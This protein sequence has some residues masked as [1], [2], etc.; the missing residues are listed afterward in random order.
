[1]ITGWF[2]HKSISQTEKN[3]PWSSYITKL[4]ALAK[5]RLGG[6]IRQD[7]AQITYKYLLCS[8]K[9]SSANH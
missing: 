4:R 5:P 8:M 7:I 6:R 2:L 3:P 1:L 9:T